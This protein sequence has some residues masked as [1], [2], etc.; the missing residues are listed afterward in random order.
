MILPIGP[1]ILNKFRNWFDF[2]ISVNT[3]LEKKCMNYKYDGIS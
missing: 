2:Q 1:M 3:V